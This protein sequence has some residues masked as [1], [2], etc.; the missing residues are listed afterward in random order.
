MRIMHKDMDITWDNNSSCSME[1]QLTLH[2]L[3]VI[4]LN[5]HMH[6][7]ICIVDIIVRDIMGV[8]LDIISSIM[9]LGLVLLLLMLNQ[10]IIRLRLL[11][12]KHRIKDRDCPTIASQFSSKYLT[13]Q[14]LIQ[15]QILLKMTQK[16]AVINKKQ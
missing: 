10:F 16:P 7:H 9:G 11:V 8:L 1:E 14:G 5:M 3:G 2:K 15:Q 4:I 12:S 13:H 6:M